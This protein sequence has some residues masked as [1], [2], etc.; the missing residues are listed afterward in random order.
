MLQADNV[1]DAEEG[2][3]AYQLRIPM[4]N[5]N[6]LFSEQAAPT[7][8]VLKEEPEK[9]RKWREEQKDRLEEK[10]TFDISGRNKI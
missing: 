8:K 2:L 10:G 5:E 1:E 6:L 4:N 7:P 3:Y 9:I